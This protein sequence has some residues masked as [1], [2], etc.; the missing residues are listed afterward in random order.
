MVP[1][2]IVEELTVKK[3]WK[4]SRAALNALTLDYCR[5]RID[6]SWTAKI[7]TWKAQRIIERL[8]YGRQ[9]TVRY[10]FTVDLNSLNR[11]IWLV[12]ESP[13]KFKIRLTA[14]KSPISLN[15]AGGSIPALNVSQSKD[16]LKMD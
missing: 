13:D 9:F 7:P 8:G 12:L 15:T 4:I 10:E 16:L 11:E 6:N 14:S 1:F 3:P 5:L 2:N